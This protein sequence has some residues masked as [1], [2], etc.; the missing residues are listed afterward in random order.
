MT[1]APIPPA[2]VPPSSSLASR[3]MDVL[4]SPGEAWEAVRIEP[5]RAS[6]WLVPVLISV[7]VGILFVC[8]AFSQAAV[9]DEVM[10]QQSAQ[11]DKAVASG[12]MSAADADKARDQV[13]AMRPM[14][15]TIVRVAGSF[16]AA[17]ASVALLFVVAAILAGI[18]RWGLGVRIPYTKWMEVAGLASLVPAL[19]TVAT[20]FL[21]LMKGSLAVS[22]GPALLVPEVRSG[23]PLQALLSALSVFNLWWCAVLAGGVSRL[24]G[25]SWGT[26]AGWVFGVFAVVTGIAVGFAAIRS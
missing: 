8:V 26:A 1:D 10:A 18:S 5:F 11:F 6:N 16:G 20:L 3:L 17:G 9:M 25:R 24:T 22:L 7:A 14:M 21:V 23:S 2:V 13:D 19:G 15:G 4:V 12:K